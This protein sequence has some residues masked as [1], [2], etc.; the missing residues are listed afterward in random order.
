MIKCRRPHCGGVLL[1]DEYELP[2]YEELVCTF[3]ADRYERIPRTKNE[4]RLIT[5][6]PVEAPS[7]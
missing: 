5:P 3:C 1:V 6:P 4:W 7:D 2:E